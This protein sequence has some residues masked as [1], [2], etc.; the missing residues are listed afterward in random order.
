M[1]RPFDGNRG[2]AET[3]PRGAILACE[4]LFRELAG[5]A[6][7]APGV[8]DLVFLP[9]GLH[10]EG[11]EAMRGRLQSEIDRL[12]EGGYREI[13]LGYGLCNNGAAGLVARR[14]PLVIPRV[15][16]CIT[17]FLGSRARYEEYFFSRPGTYFHTTGWLERGGPE[18]VAQVAGPD[19]ASDSVAGGMPSS[20]AECLARYGEEN[21]RYLWEQLDP[22]RNYRRVAYLRLPFDWLPDH[23]EWSRRLAA[24]KGWEWEEVAGDGRLLEGLVAGPRAE[25]DFLVVAP[26]G[27]VAASHDCRVIA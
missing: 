19:G 7:R 6:A 11:G 10:D 21:G 25:E 12:D 22:A 17:L 1:S 26:G 2:I 4:I 8:F 13:L 23:R 24:E 18:T 14:T 27:R 15:H 5:L 9:K 16:D 20:L 3:P